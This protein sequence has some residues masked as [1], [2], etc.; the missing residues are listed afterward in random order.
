MKRTNATQ[1]KQKTLLP[2]PRVRPKTQKKRVFF[3]IENNFFSLFFIRK[4]DKTFK[5][6]WADLVMTYFFPFLFYRPLRKSQES[7]LPVTF[8]KEKFFRSCGGKSP[9][10]PLLSGLILEALGPVVLCCFQ[11]L[12][13]FCAFFKSFDEQ[14]VTFLRICRLDTEF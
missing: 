2:A 8:E 7:P 12:F 14:D 10:C 6:W 11:I 3:R 1:K 4:L 13:F 9:E 5:R